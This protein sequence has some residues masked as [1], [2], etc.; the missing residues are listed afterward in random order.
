MGPMNRENPEIPMGPENPEILARPRTER[1][2]LYCRP[3][4]APLRK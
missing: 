1:E 4:A 3:R 2:R